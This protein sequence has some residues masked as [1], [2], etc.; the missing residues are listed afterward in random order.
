M[1]YIYK[2]LVCTALF[3]IF[4]F[5]SKGQQQNCNCVDPPVSIGNTDPICDCHPIGPFLT[6]WPGHTIGTG[7]Q[8]NTWDWTNE[9]WPCYNSNDYANESSS[10]CGN[11]DLC[12]SIGPQC[13]LTS[14]FFQQTQLNTTGMAAGCYSDFLPSDG[15]ELVRKDF[16]HLSD[17]TDNPVKADAPYVILYNRFSGRLR[18]IGAWSGNG[19]HQ[20]MDINIQFLD[21][22]F[23]SNNGLD[24][25]CYNTSGLFAHYNDASPTLIDNALPYSHIYTTPAIFPSADYSFF[26]GDFQMAYDPCTCLFESGLQVYFKFVDQ[27][28]VNLQG[29]IIGNNIPLTDNTAMDQID[30]T[31]HWLASVTQDENYDVNNGLQIYNNMNA[32]SHDFADL[33]RQY[34]DQLHQAQYTGTILGAFGTAA[35]ATGQVLAGYGQAGGDNKPA[36]KEDKWAGI[37]QAA[38]GAVNFIGAQ[39][40]EYLSPTSPPTEPFVLYAQTK[41]SGTIMEATTLGASNIL[42]GNPGCANSQSLPEYTHSL[43]YNKPAY[44]IYNEVMGVFSLLEP[45]H[46]IQYNTGSGFY[47]RVQSPSEIKYVINPATNPDYSR[48]KIQAAWEYDISFPN[49]SRETLW[50][51]VD[52]LR[53]YVINMEPAYVHDN[54]V[55]WISPFKDISCFS[56]LYIGKENIFGSTGTGNDANFFMPG[57]L[58]IKF[59]VVLVSND[60][61]HN[62]LRNTSAFLVRYKIPPSYFTYQNVSGVSSLPNYVHI[63]ERDLTID[64]TTLL[65]LDTPVLNYLGQTLILGDINGFRNIYIN[66]D[67]KT[68]YDWYMSQG[69]NLQGSPPIVHINATNSIIVAPGVNIDPNII[70]EIVPEN[71]PCGDQITPYSDV[72]AFCNGSQYNA[73]KPSNK[74][75]SPNEVSSSKLY[76]STAFGLSLYPNPA[77][78]E[79]TVRFTMTDAADVTITLTDMMGREVAT[80]DRSRHQGGTSFVPFRTDSYAPGLYLVHFSDGTHTTTQRLSIGSGF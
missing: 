11:N 65:S 53:D 77:S 44:P 28:N 25:S 16:G 3:C 79:C 10:N 17:G 63:T 74:K 18:V 12:S 22:D 39:V 34:I 19:A 52:A 71:V 9:R 15:W 20:T 67:I 78:G 7:F 59:S 80:L 23:W 42:I 43:P 58:Y 54:G 76:A 38:G 68:P 32:L 35:T 60:V 4:I 1:K 8:T 40:Q 70:L 61:D 51:G 2:E 21:P 64:N 72:K 73:K 30:P 66:T 69:I 27:L 48:T 26:Y 49:I 75:V 14:P 47:Y 33:Q 5:Y 62:G 56:N 13:G 37:L 41:L 6:T 45:P 55:D 24:V 29:N 50:T 57:D 36:K 31:H 46:V